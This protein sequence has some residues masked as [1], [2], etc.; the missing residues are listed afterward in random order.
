MF[1]HSAKSRDWRALDQNL[2]NVFG[3]TNTPP[4]PAGQQNYFN[5]AP[6]N[7]VSYNSNPATSSHKTQEDFD[8]WGDFSSAA[9]SSNTAAPSFNSQGSAPASQSQF[10]GCRYKIFFGVEH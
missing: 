8:D 10:I 7:N 2:E 6:V 3:A 5:A 1:Q 4:T 9:S